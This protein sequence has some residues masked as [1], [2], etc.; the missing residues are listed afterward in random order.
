MNIFNVKF[1]SCSELNGQLP[2]YMACITSTYSNNST[3][4]TSCTR[5]SSSTSSISTYQTYE[6]IK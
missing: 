2:C 3:I 1:L 4:N 5:N 6:F